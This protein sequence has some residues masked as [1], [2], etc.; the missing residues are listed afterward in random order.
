[1]DL[2]YIPVHFKLYIYVY[3]NIRMLEIRNFQF[4]YMSVSSDFLSHLSFLLYTRQPVLPSQYEANKNLWEVDSFSK[5]NLKYT[6]VIWEN[7]CDTLKCSSNSRC[8]LFVQSKLEVDGL[9]A[10]KLYQI[11]WWELILHYSGKQT[12]NA[13]SR[14]PDFTFLVKLVPP[15]WKESSL[16]ASS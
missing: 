6:S 8:L 2:I 16:T 11:I 1:M 12:S 7:L 3:I 4:W 5:V 10:E 13:A 15:K 14:F 9:N